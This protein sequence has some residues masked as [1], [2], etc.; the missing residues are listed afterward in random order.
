MGGNAGKHIF[1]LFP[2]HCAYGFGVGGFTYSIILIFSSSTGS[3]RR[4]EKI[5]ILDGT[6][7]PFPRSLPW[8][9]F[10]ETVEYGL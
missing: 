2:V 6:R 8:E 9:Q 3:F 4:V 5:Q 1:L 10:T 7:I